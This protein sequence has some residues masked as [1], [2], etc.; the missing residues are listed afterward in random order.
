MNRNGELNRF[1]AGTPVGSLTLYNA[2]NLSDQRALSVDPSGQFNA[3]VK[4]GAYYDRYQPIASSL[5]S[6]DR[7]AAQRLWRVTESLRGPFGRESHTVSDKNET[8]YQQ[9]RRPQ[10]YCRSGDPPASR[11]QHGSSFHAGDPPAGAKDV[12]NT[13][14]IECLTTRRCSTPARRRSAPEP[15]CESAQ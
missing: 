15:G 1:E 8:E 12:W 4:A 7:N 14:S 10:G 11:V 5:A 3:T 9:A 6:Y 13:R 2:S